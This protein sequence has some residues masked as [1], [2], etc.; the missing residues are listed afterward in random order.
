MNQKIKVL[1]ADDHPLVRKGI[2]ATLTDERDFLVVGE[3]ADGKTVQKLCRELQ[4][5]VLLLDL[6]MPESSP[7]EILTYLRTHCPEIKVLVLTAYDDDAYIYGL[8]AAG[9]A[10]YMLKDEAILR[11]VP[12]GEAGRTVPLGDEAVAKEKSVVIG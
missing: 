3:A 2:R 1:L 7:I 12:Q 8:P 11:F 10:G 5:D 4:P 6:S 9:V